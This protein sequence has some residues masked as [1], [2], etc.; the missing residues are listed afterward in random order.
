MLKF[1]LRLLT[2]FAAA[3]KDAKRGLQVSLQCCVSGPARHATTAM[4]AILVKAPRSEKRSMATLG[5]ASRTIFASRKRSSSSS[6]RPAVYRES[7]G[8]S[9]RA[10]VV[11]Q[12]P[13]DRYGTRH[14]REAEKCRAR[15]GSSHL[16]DQRVSAGL[17]PDEWVAST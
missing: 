4:A 11:L 10:G 17:G 13:A 8:F 16:C 6:K 14:E 3:K 12:G 1:H 5:R 2:R 9:G 15:C 7:P